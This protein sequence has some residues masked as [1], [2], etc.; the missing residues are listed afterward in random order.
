MQVK[1]LSVLHASAIISLTLGSKTQKETTELI[2]QSLIRF[3]LF[4][5]YIIDIDVLVRCSKF[6][7]LLP[8]LKR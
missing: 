1:F 3:I 6:V 4:I 7:Y 2:V 8:R 5:P